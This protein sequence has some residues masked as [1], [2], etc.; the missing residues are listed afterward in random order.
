VVSGQLLQARKITALFFI[1]IGA[2]AEQVNHWQWAANREMYLP[3]RNNSPIFNGRKEN[4]LNRNSDKD[5]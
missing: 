3:W 4:C 2:T 5:V 1:A